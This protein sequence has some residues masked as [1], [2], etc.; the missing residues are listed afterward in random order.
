MDMPV[1]VNH[2]QL[3]IRMKH[4]FLKLL[5]KDRAIRVQYGLHA[6][7]LMDMFRGHANQA[8]IQTF[9]LA[10]GKKNSI[11]ITSKD[12][13]RIFDPVVECVYAYD[14]IDFARTKKSIHRKR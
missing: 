10:T 9:P 7:F 6:V 11:A 3:L 2:F 13:S 8:R 14:V 5:E 4:G 1:Q 12:L